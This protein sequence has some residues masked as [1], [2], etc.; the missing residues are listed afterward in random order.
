MSASLV[1][2]FRAFAHNNAW[3]NHRLLTACAGLSHDEFAELGWTEATGAADRAEAVRRRD[4]RLQDVHDA[5]EGLNGCV[6]KM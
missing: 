3:A 5:H 2:T 1:Q 6:A 4:C